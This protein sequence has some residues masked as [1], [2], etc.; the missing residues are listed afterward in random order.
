VEFGTG[1]GSDHLAQHEDAAKTALQMGHT[2]NAILFNHYRDLVDREEAA[3]YWNIL[4]REGTG[5]VEL[6]NPA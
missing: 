2:S 5:M 6:A 3:A 4:P 1:D